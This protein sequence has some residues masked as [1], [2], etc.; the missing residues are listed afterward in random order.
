ML[1]AGSN[2]LNWSEY[3][4]WFSVV[5]EKANGVKNSKFIEIAK[6]REVHSRKNEEN[7]RTWWYSARKYN[8]RNQQSHE[9]RKRNRV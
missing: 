2:T 6:L 3:R 4:K 9:S 7:D 1:S 8:A 5:F